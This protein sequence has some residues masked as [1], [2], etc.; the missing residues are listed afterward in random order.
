VRCY[1]EIK[2]FQ[3]YVAT[4]Q[5]LST[6]AGGSNPTVAT[7]MQLRVYN[8]FQRVLTTSRYCMRPTDVHQEQFPNC[9]GTGP[10]AGGYSISN[11]NNCFTT[12]INISLSGN[13]GKY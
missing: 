5:L 3:Y 2:N 12:A 11:S 1:C 13:T 8:P 10:S 4:L 6:V 7:V 9:Y